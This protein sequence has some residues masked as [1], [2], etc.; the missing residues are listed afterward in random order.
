MNGQNLDAPYAPTLC[1][2]LIALCPRRIESSCRLNART[3]RWWSKVCI[4]VILASKP[5]GTHE[6][7][8]E[9]GLSL[10]PGECYACED[11]QVTNTPSTHAMMW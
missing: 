1:S 5:S 10:I 7:A 9:I 4:Q 3:V 6:L 8:E 2:L 11:H